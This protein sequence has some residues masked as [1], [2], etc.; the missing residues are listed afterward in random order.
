MSDMSQSSVFTRLITSF[1]TRPLRPR[2]PR[3][4]FLLFGGL[5]LIVAAANLWFGSVH[6][7]PATVWHVLTGSATGDETTDTVWRFIVLESRLPAALTA[8]LTGASLAICGLLLQSYFRNPL[9]GPSILGITAGANLGVACVVLTGFVTPALLTGA[10]F[11]GAAAILLL[12]LLLSR[13][14]RHPVTLL[15]AGI[16]VSYLTGSAITLLNYYATAEG[17]HSFLIWGMGNFSGVGLHGLPVYAAFITAGLLLSTLLIRPL[18]G[19]MLG[20]LYARNLGISPSRTRL[21]VLLVTG[22]L[23][24]ATTAYCG[25]IAFIGLCVPHLARLLFRTDNHRLLLPASG[26][27]GALC[28]SLCLLVST[29]PPDGRLLPLNAITPLFG[30]PVI[31][32]VILRRAE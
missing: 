24:A 11:V 14:V 16:L 13:L 29:L 20:D 32:Y 3:L 26:L 17:V 15:I 2:S 18:N 25:P 23:A 27:L 1:I 12:L 22:L 7:P 10:A 28:A 4:I 19:W 30:V 5:T 21:L 8:M 9:A 6:I 31:L